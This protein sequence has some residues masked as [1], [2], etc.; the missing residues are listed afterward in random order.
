[1]SKETSGEIEGGID[2]ARLKQ[3]YLAD[4]YVTMAFTVNQDYYIPGLVAFLSDPN[5]FDI[6]SGWGLFTHG[7]A[8]PPTF[9]A[10]IIPVMPPVV[11]AF[12][13]K[14]T[15][16]FA[17]TACLVRFDGPVRVQH[18]VPASTM[19]EFRKR[20]SMIFVTRVAVDGNLWLWIEG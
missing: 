17:T 3:H 1:M 20:F 2:Y 14:R 4:D 12:E 9:L 13:A 18:F 10:G 8:A 6:N 11:P 19:L 16:M 7:Q 15:R 5:V